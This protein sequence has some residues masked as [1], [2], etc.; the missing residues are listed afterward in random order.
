MKRIV[1]CIIILLLA[2]LISGCQ[3]AEDD[4][5]YT[6]DEKTLVQST[7]EAYDYSLYLNKHWQQADYKKD[8][9]IENYVYKN[10][11]NDSKIYIIKNLNP[12]GD[13]YSS[14]L[15]VNEIPQYID[16]SS[17]FYFDDLRQ[18]SSTKDYAKDF[19]FL[20]E[21]GQYEG[22]KYQAIYF[23]SLFTVPS[24]AG[25]TVP[26]CILITYTSDEDKESVKEFLTQIKNSIEYR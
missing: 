7:N 17:F 3:F 4:Y 21:T 1:M 13:L 8:E 6:I 15:Q 24:V 11:E 10:S 9:D 23:Q 12:I 16:H 19:K 26:N 25:K 14:N 22:N 5:L 18:E 2:I 20:H